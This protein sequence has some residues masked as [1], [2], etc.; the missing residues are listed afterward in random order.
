MLLKD[1]KSI[2]VA[3]ITGYLGAGKTTVLNR[4]LEDPKGHKAAVIVNDIG[5]VNIDADLI[6]KG[7]TVT[8]VDD[9]LIPLQNGCICCTLKNDL[10]EQITALA[11]MNQ[12]DYILIEASGICEPVPIAQTITAM[13]DTAVARGI[14]QICHLDTIVSVVDSLRMAEE[15]DCGQDFQEKRVEY[16]ENEDVRSLVI[17][18]IE[19]ANTIVMNKV[20]L[21]SE[22]QKG[23]I[24][25]V[26][27]AL[28]PA[29][30]IVEASYG[31]I[32][33]DDV[34]DTGNFDFNQSY[35]NL[36][37]VKAM[38]EEA[39]P[40]QH[41]GTHDHHHDHDH[42]L[43]YGI[44]TFVYSSRKPFMMDALTRLTQN[45][46]KSVIRSKGYL[47]Y[48]LDPKYL[49]IFEQAGS[50]FDTGRD[51]IWIAACDEEIKE[52]EFAAD[53][54]LADIWDDRYGDREN[55]IVFIGKDMDKQAIIAM[56]DACSTEDFED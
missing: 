7:G 20:E 29:A 38:R 56:M 3:L 17:Q 30:K 10:I 8:Q 45:W 42:V 9:S 22:E 43:E 26:I 5:E 27:H 4:I 13:E 32:D 51:S 39:Q 36:G 16:D 24:K 35:Y 19:F 50:Q 33:I 1:V 49:Y 54:T 18:Q 28:C 31:N 2:P 34:I 48:D 55:K 14:P 40:V 6:E 52:R 41:E 11:E 37:W 44:D 25:A 53:P 21:V 12:F 46:P 47:W 23:Q 15:F